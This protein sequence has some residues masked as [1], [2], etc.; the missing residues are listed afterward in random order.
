M[1]ESTLKDDILA[2]LVKERTRL[3]TLK[4]AETTEADYDRQGLVVEFI[5]RIRNSDEARPAMMEISYGYLTRI[6]L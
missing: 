5:R 3:N 6:N 1:A 4:P 2:A